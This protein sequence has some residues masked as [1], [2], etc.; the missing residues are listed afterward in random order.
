MDNHGF[1]NPSGSGNANVGIRKPLPP[2]LVW[3]K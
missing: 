3:K 2:L 1:D